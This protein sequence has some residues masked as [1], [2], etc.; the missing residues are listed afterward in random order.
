MT[1]ASIGRLAM[2]V[3]GDKWNAYYAM[4]DTLVGAIFLGSIPMKFVENNE[5]RHAFISLMRDCVA[6]IIE[7]VTGE[8]PTWTGEIPAPEHERSGNS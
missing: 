7:E 8:R 4:P 1:K 5:R 2:R 6:D 3:E